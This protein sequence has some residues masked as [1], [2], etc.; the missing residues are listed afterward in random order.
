MQDKETGGLMSSDG[1]M[2]EW[3]KEHSSDKGSDCKECLQPCQLQSQQYHS[4]PSH[5]TKIMSL[6]EEEDNE[7]EK[8]KVVKIPSASPVPLG[9]KRPGRKTVPVSVQI[10]PERLKLP[11]EKTEYH[12]TVC[13]KEFLHAYK[14][15]RHQLIHTGEKPYSCSICSRGFNQKGN[16][17]THYKVHLGGKSAVDV[18]DEV[19][20]A[21]AELSEHLK[22]LPGESKIRSSFLESE[23]DCKSQP[24]LQAYHVTLLKDT[25]ADSDLD[26]DRRLQFLFCHRCG[27]HFQEKE[28]LEEH[29]KTHI[30]DKPYSCPDCGKRFINE[31][32]S[33]AEELKVHHRLHTGERPYQCGEC[34][35]SFIYRQGLRQHQLTHSGR[36][37][38]PIGRPK[39]QILHI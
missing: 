17:K 34:G 5:A 3:N 35:K 14:L 37:I 1:E 27:V 8:E 26:M 28:K 11:K 15:E 18:V 2:T 19:N 22:S 30:K 33:R 39:Q 4:N 20:P 9:K 16:L 12:C 21:A 7:E 13:G 32:Y 25:A 23:K 24:A 29:M 10:P 38:R 31:S 6:G 36:R